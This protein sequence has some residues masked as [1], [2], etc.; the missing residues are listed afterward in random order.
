M[1]ER[2]KEMPIKA[3]RL[4]LWVLSITALFLL[5][6]VV[7]LVCQ[8]QSYHAEFLTQE[9]REWLDAHPVITLGPDPFF[10]PIEF[11]DEDGTYRG[12]A[13]DYITL[14]EENLGIKFKIVR[15]EK[16]D[17]VVRQAQN[18]HI[19]VWGAATNSP[20]RS[21]YMLFTSPHIELPGVII[22]RQGGQEKLTME[23]L[24]NMRV[25]VVSSYIWQDFIE[26]DYPDMELK[27]VPDIQTGLKEVS[28][29][30]VDVF[31]NDLATTSYYIEKEGIT[32]LC[33][34]GE[35]GYFTRLAFASRSD[36]P[37][38]NSI[39]EKG[40]AQISQ[41]EVKSILAKWVHLK[42]E[43]FFD[44]K[45][46]WIS[47]FAGLG[48]I[49]LII[50]SIIVWN[51]SLKKKVELRT[52][53]LKKEL[54][55]RKKLEEELKK[56]R[57]EL[58]LRVKERTVEVSKLSRAIEQSSSAVIITDVNGN[59]EYV[60]PG[61]TQI[62]GYTPEEAIGKNPSILKS[63]AQKPEF[64]E[65]MW[66]T[67]LSGNEWQ[68]EFFN[69]RKNEELYWELAS[70][71]PIKNEEGVT[72]NYIAVKEDITE[73]K[74]AE[75]RLKVAMEEAHRANKAKS[76]FLSSMSHELRTP[77][78]AVLGFAQ[79]LYSDDDEPLSETQKEDVA[80]ILKSGN[81]LLELINEVL[82]L[83]GIESG[84]VQ[85]SLEEI[86]ID[87]IINEVITTVGPIAQENKITINYR[88]KCDEQYIMADR[89]R[90]NQVLIN[91][92]SNAIKYNKADGSVTISC[93]SSNADMIRIN[94]EDTGPGIAEENHDTL[95]EPFNRL[96]AETLN[97]EGT[98]VGLT[99][100]KKLVEMMDGRIGVGS[101]VGKGTRFQ[102]DFKKI[103]S[104]N[105]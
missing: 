46:F 6:T 19:D 57:D 20:Q 65:E 36:W 37:E 84:K 58:E 7:A 39:L 62:T 88:I 42:G 54:I 33:V 43:T 67:L 8:A 32:N 70:I 86:E 68:G 59:I 64:Y 10:P 22:S 91:L 4:L 103:N 47:L 1:S 90:L 28:F 92:L 76:V 101:V 45:E 78:N 50:I 35:T 52:E 34:V 16:W 48:L 27:L 77:M 21:K 29:G 89:M 105:Y 102:V 75:S 31:I 71:S 98:G 66:R 96:G 104:L 53:D 85:I 79:L 25:A 44:K 63:D 60:N 61:F 17:E 38:L 23:Q 82:D 11:L 14:I 15:L 26:N 94:I 5:N 87:T 83:S 69:K 12:I 81:H 40:L 24:K 80:H 51:R 73:R 9:E 2:N 41:A 95:F 18:R 100:T 72:T 74:Q 55:E 56:S 49:I 13:A 3:R 30:T 93:E 97:I 99:I